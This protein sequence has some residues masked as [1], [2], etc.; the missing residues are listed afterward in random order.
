[1]A[2]KASKIPSQLLE[3]LGRWVCQRWRVFVLIGSLCRLCAQ[4]EPELL[5]VEEPMA[6]KLSLEE[7]MSVLKK[8]PPVIRHIPKGAEE[9]VS[10]KFAEMWSKATETRS[11]HD[12]AALQLFSA[13]CLSPLERGGRKHCSQAARTVRQ[14]VDHFLEHTFHGVFVVGNQ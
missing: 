9:A 1:M 13:N 4:F 10:E 14:R 8:S 2:A 11:V 7:A 3:A 5:P 12:V 6:P